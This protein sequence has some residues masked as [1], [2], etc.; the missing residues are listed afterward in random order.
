MSADLDARL[1]R[2]SPTQI[3]PSKT[4]WPA[5][6]Y[7]VGKKCR[8]EYIGE[9]VWAVW[10]REFSMATQ[11]AEIT[12]ETRQTPVSGERRWVGAPLVGDGGT[13]G[14]PGGTTCLYLDSV[15]FWT[16]PESSSF[17]KFCES[18]RICVLVSVQSCEVVEYLT[19]LRECIVNGVY[20]WIIEHLGLECLSFCPK[21]LNLQ[22]SKP[23]WNLTWHIHWCIPVG[24]KYN[25]AIG[26]TPSVKEGEQRL[27][28]DFADMILARLYDPSPYCPL[29]A[30]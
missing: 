3:S 14:H 22:I 24:G 1:P 2:P 27:S 11:S 9:D 17:M 12:M 26:F 30:G 20:W 16:S 7:H 10:G 8:A 23:V 19:Y 25:M 28:S 5:K 13:K 4:Y 18:A 29:V 6:K 15:N 21:D